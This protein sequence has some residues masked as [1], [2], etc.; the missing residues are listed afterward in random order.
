MNFK[1]FL[2]KE[3][4]QA[5]P[6]APA[7]TGMMMDTAGGLNQG[8]SSPA[9]LGGAMGGGANLNL[10]AGNMGLGGP[11]MGL[12]G[13]P[14]AATKPPTE[15]HFSNVWTVLEKILDEKSDKK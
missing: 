14:P 1:Q 5:A 8:L 11:D 9:N 12:G 10:G 4:P 15:I 6:M 13:S 2:F 7:T 3:A